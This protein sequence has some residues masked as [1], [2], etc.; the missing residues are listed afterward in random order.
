ME[1][2]NVQLPPLQNT[3][4]EALELIRQ[5]HG[6][7]FEQV[8]DLAEHDPGM[9]AR[10]LRI[11]N[12]AYYGQ[13]RPITSIHRAV[14]IMGTV[15]VTGIVMAMSMQQ[16]QVARPAR[17]PW[18]QLIRH[19]VATA[20]LA[21]HLLAHDPAS[22]TAYEPERQRDV[23]TAGLLHDVGKM[24]LLYNNPG[25]A[26]EFYLDPSAR[27]QSDAEVLEQERAL[28]GYDH[29]EAGVYLSER[30]QFPD[31]L[32]TTIAWHHRYDQLSAEK[33][34]IKHVL[35]PVVAANQAANVLGYALNHGTTS[36]READPWA[37]LLE[38]NVVGYRSTEAM[39]EEVA[40][41]EG[42]LAA[43]VE[44]VA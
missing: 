11:V 14:M 26:A 3:V 38:E 30:L 36:S 21:R 22:A 20:F 35:Y 18:K 1:D 17:R 41:L 8:I 44:A 10:L 29:V 28:L 32:T 19:S 43:Y 39:L 25:A 31:V 12:S 23:F 37:L 40:A 15:P 2:L 13:R 4:I 6:P 42:E 33:E 24:V 27:A 7:E 16:A 9:V 34:A 5:P